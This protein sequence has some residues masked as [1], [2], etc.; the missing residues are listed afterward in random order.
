[1]AQYKEIVTKAIIGKGKKATNSTY[2]LNTD[3]EPNTVLGCWVI[4][5][6]FSG[7]NSGD[8]IKVDGTFDVNVWYSYDNNSKTSV[9]TGKFNYSDK[10]NVKLRNDTE[11][12][13]NSEIIV[14][15][16]TQPTVTNVSIEDSKVKLDVTKELGIEI[17]GDTKVKIS[18]EDEEDEYEEI[19][20]DKEDEMNKAMKEIDEQVDENNID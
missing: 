15:S 2:Y 5:H 4:N 13:Y 7:R 3:E 17:V 18:V 9:S 6:N 1:M 20:D 16:L 8:G 19:E 11:M 10:M 12:D 14:R